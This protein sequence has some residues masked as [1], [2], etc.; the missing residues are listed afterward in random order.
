V[1]FDAVMLAG[2]ASRRM[3]AGGGPI[4]KVLLVVGGRSLLQRVADAARSAGAARVIS[5]GPPRPGDDDLQVIAVAEDQPG[6]GPAAALGTAMRIVEHHQIVLLAG[7]LP[8]VDA[9]TITALRRRLAGDE[10]AP[11]AVT[12]DD[13]GRPQWLLSAW[14]TAALVEALAGAGVL[15]GRPLRSVLEPLRPV[16]TTVDWTG[17]LPPWFDCDSPE[18]LALARRAVAP[19]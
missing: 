4:D 10:R 3:A 6:Q 9:G 5:V 13:R 17:P 11:G 19:D 2:G 14:R 15:A 8:F 18:D 7:D 1:G 16:P 12:V